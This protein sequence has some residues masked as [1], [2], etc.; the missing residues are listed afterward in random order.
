MPSLQEVLRAAN[1]LT[2]T[3]A[4]IADQKKH[5][6]RANE[7]RSRESRAFASSSLDEES[8]QRPERFLREAPR[9]TTQAL[10]RVGSKRYFDRFK[11]WPV[12][13][14]ARQKECRWWK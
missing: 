6:Q 8:T 4:K 9:E 10:S 7:G 5:Q 12:A 1:L 3:Q 13:P 11:K 14:A 2:E